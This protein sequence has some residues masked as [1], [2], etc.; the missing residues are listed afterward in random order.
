[1]VTTIK[2]IIS[3]VFMALVISAPVIRAT[4]EENFV[5]PFRSVLNA[6]TQGGKYPMVFN[7]YTTHILQN[8]PAQKDSSFS[9][10]C[11]IAGNGCNTALKL[12]TTDAGL[13]CTSALIMGGVA[14]YNR[15]AITKTVKNAHDKTRLVFTQKINELQGK[16]TIITEKFSDIKA[17]IATENGALKTWLN[18]LLNSNHTELKQQLEKAQTELKQLSEN[19]KQL[20]E[21]LEKAR[22]ENERLHK[23]GQAQV[24]ALDENI[25]Q[26]RTEHKDAL[27]TLTNSI[28]TLSKQ[29]ENLT[30][31]IGEPTT[32]GQ[33]IFN[34][35]RYLPGASA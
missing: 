2:K 20:E 6:A 33:T 34:I 23:E 7:T 3:A 29:I 28:V 11:S 8:A 12:M 31:R 25:E 27:Q 32:I 17:Q 5:S 1:M 16:L 24:A 10:I 30:Q 13:Y 15:R 19:K 21:Q 9:K 18:G 22:G 4:N 26:M 14:Y 35:L